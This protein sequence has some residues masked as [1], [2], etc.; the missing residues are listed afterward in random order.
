MKSKN[1]KE[2]VA[3]MIKA[4]NIILIINNIKVFNKRLLLKINSFIKAIIS[5]SNNTQAKYKDQDKS[6][7]NLF[8]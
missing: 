8:S 2:T 1:I 7:P 3:K 4:I 5:S 6:N